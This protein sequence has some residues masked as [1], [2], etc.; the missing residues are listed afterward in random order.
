MHSS[1]AEGGAQD[2]AEP[3]E[4]WD[5]LHSVL[6]SLAGAVSGL[7]KRQAEPD[8]MAI[9]DKFEAKLRLFEGAE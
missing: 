6:D 4:G 2:E 8:Q 9:F 7:L 5:L 3:V 1:E